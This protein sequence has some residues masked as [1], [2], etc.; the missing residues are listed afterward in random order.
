MDW[1]GFT[2]DALM[3]LSGIVIL[4]YAYRIL[5]KPTSDNENTGQRPMRIYKWFGWCIIAMAV[6][7]F[8]LH[9]LQ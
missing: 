8:V 5:G 6:T 3:A 7:G 9:V 1:I 2:G 4:L